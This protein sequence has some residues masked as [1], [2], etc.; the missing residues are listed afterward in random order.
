MDADAKGDRRRRER[1]AE[2]AGKTG[3]GEGGAAAGG[4]ERTSGDRAAAPRS[5]SSGKVRRAKRSSGGTEEEEEKAEKERGS[6]SKSRGA[7]RGTR[8]A[9]SSSA[10]IAASR[11]VGKPPAAASP[12]KVDGGGGAAA[13]PPGHSRHVSSAENMT[14]SSS[15]SSV[16]LSSWAATSSSSLQLGAGLSGGFPPLATAYRLEGV[17]GRG[18]QAPGAVF[19]RRPRP[20]SRLFR[21]ICLASGEP[22]T[23]RIVDMDSVAASDPGFLAAV[24]AELRALWRVRHANVTPL[25]TA[26]VDDAALWIVTGP[27]AVASLSEMVSAAF[28]TGVRDEEALAL[29]MRDVV[30]ALDHVHRNGI[31][32]RDIRAGNIRFSSQ[33]LVQLDGFGLSKVV[34]DVTP[35]VRS[36]SSAALA[37]AETR[38]VLV[39][40]TGNAIFADDFVGCPHSMAPEVMEQVRGYDQTADIWSVGMLMLEL[41]HGRPSMHDRDALHVIYR[42]LDGSSPPELPGDTRFSKHLERFLNACL[43]KNGAK[44]PTAAQLLEM[45]FL[46]RVRKLPE[47]HRDWLSAL[48]AVAKDTDLFNNVLASVKGKGS[49]LGTSL[50]SDSSGPIDTAPSADAVRRAD[51]KLRPEFYAYLGQKGMQTVETVAPASSRPPRWDFS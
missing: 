50:A 47:Q 10:T 45:P 12:A 28:P 14:P 22:C 2:Q 37:D 30:R 9:K 20:M 40:A 39:D 48:P 23:V 24:N 42:T 4:P 16:S 17:L 25:H 5:R 3:E 51:G 35:G 11:P 33:G 46:A 21:A 18:G 31:F 43:E 8:V 7:T 6:A 34:C 1:A 41:V 15:T 38:R 26:F 32:H 19:G 27:V 29:V 13:L 36:H 49:T 44:R